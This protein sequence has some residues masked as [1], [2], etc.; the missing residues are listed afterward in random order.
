MCTSILW[1]FSE[2]AHIF[3]GSI[4]RVRRFFSLLLKCAQVS[5][6]C[7]PKFPGPGSGFR[8]LAGGSSCWRAVTLIPQT[9]SLT[10]GEPA[11]PCAPNRPRPPAVP[12]KSRPGPAAPSRGGRGPAWRRRPAAA[13]EALSGNN[14]PGWSST[15]PAALSRCNWS[16][17]RRRPVRHRRH[18]PGSALT[19][20]R[21]SG[22]SG[23]RAQEGGIAHARARITSCWG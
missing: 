13:V 16:V 18:L 19:C 10:A 7:R 8:V 3:R 4:S 21:E 12:G 2:S 15:C 14:L 5:P 20:D 23:S 22:G 6:P 1:T 9:F 17:G 11:Q